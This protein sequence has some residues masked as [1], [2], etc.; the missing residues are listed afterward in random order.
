MSSTLPP[1]TASGTRPRVGR[2]LIVD[3]EPQAAAAMVGILERQYEVVSLS[4]PAEAV[5][6]IAAG[7][8][9]DVV[10]YDL[11][12]RGM[13]GA[14]VFARVCALSTRQAARIV[15][16][17]GGT[18]PLAL[19]EFLSRVSNA[20]LQRPVNLEVLRALVDRRVAEELARDAPGSSKTG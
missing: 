2:V 13:T 6:R 16:L 12:M 3:D 18:M 7:V 20:C 11:T 1:R 8:R 19:A 10:L 14:E 9:F 17:G 15:F 5:A 4:D